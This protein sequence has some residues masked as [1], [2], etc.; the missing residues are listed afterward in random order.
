MRW[1]GFYRLVIRCF[2]VHVERRKAADKTIRRSEIRSD[3]VLIPAAQRPGRTLQATTLVHETYL[4]LVDCR[5]VRWQDRN[6]FLA[7]TAKLMR[8]ILVDYARSAPPSFQPQTVA[9]HGYAGKGHGGRCDHGR[10]QAQR[11]H[12][13]PHRVIGEGPEQVLADYPHCP[14]GKFQGFGHAV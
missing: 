4:Q 12:G 2:R 1:P 9:H 7:V 14:A 13:D 6:H 5:R 8:R 10:E 3:A 11:R